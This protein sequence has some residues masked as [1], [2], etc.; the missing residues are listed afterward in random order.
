MKIDEV[1]H[2]GETPG[3]DDLDVGLEAVEGKFEADLVITLARAAV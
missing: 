1:G 3:C 2:T